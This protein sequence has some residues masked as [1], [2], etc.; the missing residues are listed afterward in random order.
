MDSS[1]RL[2]IR[3]DMVDSILDEVEAIMQNYQAL[4]V[5]EQ[6]GTELQRTN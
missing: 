3:R 1:Y 5:E 6:Y 2:L 4:H